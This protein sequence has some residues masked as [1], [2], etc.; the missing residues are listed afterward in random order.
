MIQ[1]II[2]ELVNEC[3]KNMVQKK[4]NNLINLINQYL[5]YSYVHLTYSIIFRHRIIIL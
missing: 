2:L 1:D 5:M 4:W 3:E